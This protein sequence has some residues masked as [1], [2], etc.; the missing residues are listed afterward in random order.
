MNNFYHG[1]IMTYE[2]KIL[3]SKKKLLPEKEYQ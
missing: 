1:E 3:E 2:S